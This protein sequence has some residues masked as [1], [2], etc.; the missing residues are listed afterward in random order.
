MPILPS[1]ESTPDQSALSLLMTQ[2]PLAISGIQ[3]SPRIIIHI[4][5]L[6][7]HLLVLILLHLCLGFPS[8]AVGAT[9]SI[10]TVIRVSSTF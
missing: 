10:R 7:V 4:L 6:R 3:S 9:N 2:L 1:Q 5:H 8:L